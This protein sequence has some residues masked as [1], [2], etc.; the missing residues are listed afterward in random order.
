MRLNYNF[1]FL[2]VYLIAIF[3][4]LIFS[5]FIA[6]TFAIVLLIIWI[7]ATAL[8]SV[9]LFGSVVNHG[10]RKVKKVSLTF[11]DGPYGNATEKILDILKEKNVKATFFVLGNNVKKYPQILKRM[12]AEGHLIGNHGLDHSKL[13]FL[14]SRKNYSKN[15]NASEEKI[16]SI[17][18]KRPK[19]FRPPWGL[20]SLEMMLALRS[21]S[22]SIILWD[23]ITLDPFSWAGK[24]IILG[25]II[26]NLRPGSIIVLH[27][28][29]DTKIDY[30]RENIIEALPNIIDS[31]QMKG[32][33]IVPLDR[34]IGE[35]AYF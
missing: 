31:I 12:A 26:N 21:K 23:I 15:I 6:I 11:D 29:R 10:N 35:K 3:I 25:K 4:L 19:F 22:Y 14:K 9:H 27:D 13:L 24:K 17:L 18:G 2:L 16:F 5:K 33:E 20:K 7:L 32:F 28:G 1:I 8:P 34:L 30:P